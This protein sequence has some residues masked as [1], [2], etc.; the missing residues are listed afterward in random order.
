MFTDVHFFITLIVYVSMN[1]S[2]SCMLS[3]FSTYTFD[4]WLI[5]IYRK[6]KQSVKQFKSKTLNNMT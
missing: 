6:K 1:L 3:V 4:N 5:Y 2:S